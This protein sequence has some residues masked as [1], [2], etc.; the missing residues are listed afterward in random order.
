MTK[1]ILIIRGWKS[2]KKNWRK[3]IEILEKNGFEVLSPNL[4]GFTKKLP[5]KKPWRIDDYKNWL[6]DYL[7]DK[8]WAKFN[9]LGHS[10]GGAIAIK[11]AKE[12][13]EK[14]EKIVLVA[15]AIFGTKSFKNI[16]FYI[17]ARV[18]NFFISLPIFKNNSQKIKKKLSLYGIK[19]YY[20]ERGVMAKT[21]K[22][23]S[24]EDFKE[25]LKNIYQ[26]TLIVWGRRDR[27]VS[28]KYAK[29]LKKF[30]KNS[31]LLILKE[32]GHHPQIEKP[33]EFTEIIIKF[34]KD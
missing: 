2:K 30:L 8:D 25:D 33:K 6:I 10:F 12:K 16:I 18:I 4:P 24:K 14:V 29:K 31:K 13:P 26:D 34:L 23:L 17:I 15:P 32:I 27:S 1:K 5:L 20:F 3:T 28:I 7:E 19:E 22:N 9:V 11:I 21:L